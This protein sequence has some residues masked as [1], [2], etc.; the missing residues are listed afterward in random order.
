MPSP[1]FDAPPD[2]LG[3]M[4]AGYAVFFTIALIYVASLVIRSRNLD[5]DLKTLQELQ[6]AAKMPAAKVTRK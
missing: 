3:Y 5:Q 6:K 2:T 4:I 1:L